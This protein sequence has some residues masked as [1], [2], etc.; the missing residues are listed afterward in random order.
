M[1]KV[2]LSI[3]IIMASM[4]IFYSCQ[5]DEI[6]SEPSVENNGDGIAPNYEIKYSEQQMLNWEQTGSPFLEDE[7]DNSATTLIDPSIPSYGGIFKPI[8]E[9]DTRA[10]GVHPN[11]NRYWSMIRLKVTLTQEPL[12]SFVIQAIAEIEEQTNISFYNAINDP[13]K[14]PTYGIVYPNVYINLAPKNQIGSSFIGR[15]GGEQYLYLPASADV[16]FIKR[17][18]VNVAGMYNEYQRN[19]RDTYVNIY[20]ANVHADNRFHFN[21]IT[22]NY[23]G[24]GNF[25]WYSITMAGS[26]VFSNNGSKTITMKSPNGA[27]VQNNTEL[28]NLDRAF[29]NYF[30]LPYV[31]RTDTY[32]ELNR[33]VFDGNN[34]QLTEQEVIDLE[35][36]LNNGAQ[37]PGAQFRINPVPW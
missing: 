29:L 5:Q 34:R 18:L 13:E 21:K 37:N 2:R 15:K 20:T 16:A 9:A 32:R 26:Y 36:Y 33:P 3:M 14:D 31:G 35:N 19:D 6:A 24:K 27:D 28:S 11:Q 30:Y 1:K 25:D 12:R 7:M 23:Y 8:T 4:A 17:A 10:W 22:S